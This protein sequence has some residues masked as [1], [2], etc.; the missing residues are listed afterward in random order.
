M[1]CYPEN[2]AQEMARLF[3]TLRRQHG[4]RRLSVDDFSTALAHVLSELNAIHPFREG[5]GRTQ[6]T[7]AVLLGVQAGHEMSLSRLHPESFLAAM[8]RSFS[9]GEGTLARE[10]RAMLL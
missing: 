2:I 5:N 4:L 1:F 6:L 10:I 7:F 9:H 3:A 8:I